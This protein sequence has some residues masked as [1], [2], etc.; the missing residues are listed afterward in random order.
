VDSLMICGPLY[1]YTF[2]LPSFLHCSMLSGVW[3]GGDSYCF[4]FYNV[5]TVKDLQGAIQVKSFPGA[6]L[7]ENDQAMVIEK[8]SQMLVCPPNSN[9]FFFL[10]SSVFL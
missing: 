6:V 3:K 10:K 2:E 8:G 5:R 4:N 1:T 9:C 7:Q